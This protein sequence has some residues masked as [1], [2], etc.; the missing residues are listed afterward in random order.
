MTFDQLKNGPEFSLFLLI[1]NNS[2]S[3]TMISILS[4]LQ[5]LKL[6]ANF[7]KKFKN[8]LKPEIE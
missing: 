7:S 8:Q 1:Q 2:S 3:L 6:Q 4:N 5:N